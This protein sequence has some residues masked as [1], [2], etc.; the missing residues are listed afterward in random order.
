M[1]A[2]LYCFNYKIAPKWE[3]PVCAKGGKWTVNFATKGKSDTCWLYTVCFN[4]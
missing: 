1:G 3:D 2:D 4:V